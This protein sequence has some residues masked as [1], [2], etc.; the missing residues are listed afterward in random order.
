MTLAEHRDRSPRAADS[1][2]ATFSDSRTP[3]TDTGGS[4]IAGFLEQAG[5]HVVGRSLVK[6]DSRTLAS[7]LQRILS[8]NRLDLLICTGGTGIAPRD[9]AYEHLQ[10]LYER[11]IPGFGELFRMLSWEEIGS[12]ALLSRASAGVRGD[13][14]IFSLPGSL[15]AIELAMRRLILPELQH[16][17]GELHRPATGEQP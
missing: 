3:Q 9:I 13:V 1:W 10:T 8:S 4:A 12:A 14:L 16:L 15:A 6:E 5:H 7:E 11:S 17:L 2:I